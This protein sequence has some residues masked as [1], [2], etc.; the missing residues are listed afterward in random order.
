MEAIY[1]K[2]RAKINLSLEVTGKRADNYHTLSS[3]FQKINFYDELYIQKTKSDGIIILS[4]VEDL[5]NQDNIIAKAY[6]ALKEKYENIT[7]VEVKLNKRIPMQAGLAGGSTD[8][9]SFL[10]GMNQLFFLNMQKE[11]IENIG[12]RLGA[13]VVPCFYNQAVKAEGIGDIITPIDTTC[14]YYLVIL[15]PPI[16]CNTKELFSKIDEQKPINQKRNTEKIKQELEKN[17]LKEM[18][19]YLYNV[20]E[21]VIEEKG[22][23][24]ELKKEVIKQG[25]IRKFND[26]YRFLCLWYLREERR[27]KESISSVKRKI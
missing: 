5:N 2:A 17:E 1:K 7:G 19:K 27:S 12:R 14:K 13:D 6:H 4:N 11:E 10:I 15:K 24:Q 18:A 22:L 9:A 3:V 20:F 8:C 26:R 25:A 16:A 21:E 23:I